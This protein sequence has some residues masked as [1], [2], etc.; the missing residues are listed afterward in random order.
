MREQLTTSHLDG[1][2]A[3]SS[4]C[5]SHHPGASTSQHTLGKSTFLFLPSTPLP[6]QT[7]QCPLL[8][9]L[10]TSLLVYNFQLTWLATSYL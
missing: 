9:T 6:R 1:R 5:M 4:G 7:Q 2:Q 8:P 3:G 10:L